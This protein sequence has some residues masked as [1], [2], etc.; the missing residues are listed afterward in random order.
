M[1]AM[2]NVNPEPSFVEVLDGLIA[3]YKGDVRKIV[4][5][6]LMSRTLHDAQL[7]YDALEYATETRIKGLSGFQGVSRRCL[8][9]QRC[10]ESGE[11]ARL[12]SHT[13]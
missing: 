3:R 2:P 11:S 5:Q 12:I 8:N 9:S 7:R 6:G 1:N 4:F 13:E 10:V